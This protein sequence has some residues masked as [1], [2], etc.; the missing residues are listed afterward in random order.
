MKK[1]YV[2]P[3]AEV[4]ELP[5]LMQETAL[6]TASV[7]KTG[8]G[9]TIDQIDITDDKDQHPGAGDKNIWDGWGGE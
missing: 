5:E 3:M 7:V 1:Q 4:V 6:K 9:Q 2:K 8:T